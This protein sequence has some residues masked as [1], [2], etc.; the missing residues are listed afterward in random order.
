MREL[1]YRVTWQNDNGTNVDV[2][3]VRARNIN[4]GFPKAVRI[5]LTG[6]PKGAELCSVIFWS[7][8]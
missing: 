2:V 3:T 7:A 4:S 1:K 6:L 8:S 5:A